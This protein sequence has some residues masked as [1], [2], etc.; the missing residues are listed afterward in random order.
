MLHMILGPSQIHLSM[1]FASFQRAYH[2]LLF[3]EH[4][5]PTGIRTYQAKPQSQTIWLLGSS[6]P[7]QRFRKNAKLCLVMCLWS[8]I[9]DIHSPINPR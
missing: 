6:E 7:S 4:N 8:P 2:V 1:S 5:R 3:D 9:Q